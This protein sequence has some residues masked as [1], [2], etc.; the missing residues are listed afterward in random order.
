MFKGYSLIT[1]YKGAKVKVH[2]ASQSGS[3]TTTETGVITGFVTGLGDNCIFLELD[4]ERLIN[5]RYIID[6]FIIE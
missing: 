3:E 4:E 2:I 1:G 6:M 5:A